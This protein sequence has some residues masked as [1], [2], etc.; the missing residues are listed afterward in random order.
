MWI[1]SMIQS[2]SKCC[3]NLGALLEMRK[4]ELGSLEHLGKAMVV[5]FRVLHTRNGPLKAGGSIPS[6]PMDLGKFP[7]PQRLASSSLLGPHAGRH[8]IYPAGLS[9]TQVSAKFRPFSPPPW[10][11]LQFNYLLG[12]SVF[13]FRP[14]QRDWKYPLIGEKSSNVVFLMRM[15]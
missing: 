15:K 10:G 14:I 4:S 8:L 11:Q 5:T 6:M 2:Y 3:H 7:R 9:E 13:H 12:P 1:C